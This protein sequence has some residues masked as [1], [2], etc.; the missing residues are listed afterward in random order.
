MYDP[1]TNETQPA[2]FDATGLFAAVSR[3]PRGQRVVPNAGSQE[4]RAW[5]Y[6][7]RSFFLSAWQSCP[8]W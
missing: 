5:A 1:L 6:R 3:Q 4:G 8:V 2:L 7:C